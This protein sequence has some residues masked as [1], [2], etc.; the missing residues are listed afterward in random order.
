MAN[1]RRVDGHDQLSN[2]P[3]ISPLATPLGFELVTSALIQFV[4]PQTQPTLL[5]AIAYRKCAYP[6]LIVHSPKRPQ[7]TQEELMDAANPPICQQCR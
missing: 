1:T 7:R 5:K 2:L 4:G 3:T 6:N